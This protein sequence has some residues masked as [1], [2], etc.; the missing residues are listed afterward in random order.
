MNVFKLFLNLS[1][2]FVGLKKTVNDPMGN[3]S[4]ISDALIQ[5]QY[6]E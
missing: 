5:L 2:L 6:I 4:R 3:H 1:K